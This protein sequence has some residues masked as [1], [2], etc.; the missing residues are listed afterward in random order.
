MV[1]ALLHGALAGFDR[2]VSEGL[3]SCASSELWVLLSA[4]REGLLSLP[5]PSSCIVPSSCFY[6]RPSGAALGPLTCRVLCC[7]LRLRVSETRSHTGVRHPGCF[8]GGLGPSGPHRDE[9]FGS[10]DGKDL[11]GPPEWMLGTFGCVQNP[12]VTTLTWAHRR[13]MAYCSRGSLG[14]TWS[15][16]AQQPVMKSRSL[17]GSAKKQPTQ[18]A[19]VKQGWAKVREAAVGRR[20]G[21]APPMPC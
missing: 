9:T 17:P 14:L 2:H 13:Q 10:S 16:G 12:P 11:A 5:V 15:V 8:I 3:L 21:L 4:V 20:E 7:R 18:Q 1:W 19:T 6:A